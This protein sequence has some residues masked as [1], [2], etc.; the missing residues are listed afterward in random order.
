MPKSWYLPGMSPCSYPKQAVNRQV[1]GSLGPDE[2]LIEHNMSR[3]S[4]ILSEID[5]YVWQ[6]TYHLAS[7]GHTVACA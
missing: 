2:K 6:Q 7:L 4:E 3:D 1:V 5:A